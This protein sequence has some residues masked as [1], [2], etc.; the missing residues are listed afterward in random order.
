MADV[1][2]IVSVGTPP[3][4]PADRRPPRK[5]RKPGVADA[6]RP[7]APATPAEEPSEADHGQSG[8]KH[9]DICV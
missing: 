3:E 4:R 9:L 7:P 5:R 2:R 1:D 6:E 8:Q